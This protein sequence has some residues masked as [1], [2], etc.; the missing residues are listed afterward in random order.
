MTCNLFAMVANMASLFFFVGADVC[1]DSQRVAFG[2]NLL[3][4]ARS[5][6]TLFSRFQP[7]EH[8]E[9]ESMAQ[10]P[11]SAK[12]YPK[13][14]LPNP[15]TG[16][17]H[18]FMDDHLLAEWNGKCDLSLVKS[19]KL[20][21]DVALI[22]GLSNHPWRTADVRLADFVVLPVYLGMSVAN[23]CG[24]HERNMRDL[25]TKLHSD[26]LFQQTQ[27]TNFLIPGFWWKVQKNLLQ[28]A[29]LVEN[30]TMV[31]NTG[32]RATGRFVAVPHM[33]PTFKRV[34]F[35]DRKYPLFFMGNAGEASYKDDPQRLHGW[36]LRLLAIKYLS[37]KFSNSVLICAGIPE[38]SCQG[39]QKCAAGQLSGCLKYRSDDLY[40]KLL[41]K[42]TFGLMIRG[43][44]APSEHLYDY[45]DAEV[46]PVII[47][48]PLKKYAAPFPFSLDWD[49]FTVS[50]PEKVFLSDPVTSVQHAINMSAPQRQLMMQHLKNVKSALDWTT[51]ESWIPSLVLLESARVMG[52]LSPELLKATR[53]NSLPKSDCTPCSPAFPC[54]S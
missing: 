44:T 51:P 45:I 49:A 9:L 52:I 28:M 50:I 23:A 14:N 5:N 26:A 43:A 40:A 33:H 15:D 10:T 38:E 3:Q 36:A 30:M 8:L 48:D 4:R 6:M 29:P 17:V 27:G 24:D 19:G 37:P 31:V 46:L 41:P 1:P 2:S 39:L 54:S 12:F 22:K 35:E 16:L 53:L 25:A 11:L 42:S 47:D 21:V 18:F 20:F 34:S 13:Q 32:E 7:S